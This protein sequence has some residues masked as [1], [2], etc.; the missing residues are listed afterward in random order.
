MRGDKMCPCLPVIIFHAGLILAVDK[1][2][3]GN[4]DM[5]GRKV[6]VLS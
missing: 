2:L 6:V 1:L 5:M 4:Y 3:S